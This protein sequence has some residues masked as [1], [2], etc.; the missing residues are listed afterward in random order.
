MFFFPSQMARWKVITALDV[1][2]EVLLLALPAWL[3]SRNRVKASS[4][5]V[6]VFVFS[7]RLVVAAFSLATMSTYFRFLHSGTS[8]DSIGLVPTVISIEAML[9]ASLITASIP[10]LRSFM[11]AFMSRGVFT[12]YGVDTSTSQGGSHSTSIPMHFMGRSQTDG[13]NP[14]VQHRQPGSR[15][16]L[17]PEWLEYRVD[18]RAASRAKKFK[19]TGDEHSVN[20]DGSERMIIHRQVEFDMHED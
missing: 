11:W 20:S 15:V 4:K 13:D 7:F 18:V 14:D 10:S 19:H 12:M 8:R 5:R 3:V 9:C 16:E 17:R 1:V 6:V 2:T